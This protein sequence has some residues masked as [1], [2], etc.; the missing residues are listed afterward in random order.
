MNQLRELRKMT[1]GTTLRLV[2]AAVWILAAVNVGPATGGAQVSGDSATPCKIE[3][4]VFDGWQAEQISNRW[5]KLTI[6]PQLGGRLMQV[7]F[8]G[9]PYL[10]VNSK[11]KGQYFPPSE[12]AEKGRWFN[13][14][15]DKIWPLPEG[16][17]DQHH[18]PGPISDPLDDGTYLF[19]KLSES[20]RCAVRLDGPPD[21]RT[22]LQYSREISIGNDS[23]E[24]KFHAIMKN[25]S[26]H[27]IQWS[28]QSVTQYDT[29][30]PQTPASYNHEF[31]AFTPAN[32]HSKFP[33]GYRVRSGLVD[34][35]SYAVKENLF[36]L[37][38][39]PIQNEV[40]LDSAGGWLVV[41]D[42][43]THYAIVERF[44]YHHGA[45]YPG[46]A[47]VIFY[48]NGAALELN[49]QGNPILTASHPEDALFYMEAEL[50]SPIAKLEPGE[51]YWMDT[52][53]F[54]VR[55]GKELSAVTNAGVIGVALQAAQK[56][57]GIYLTGLFGVFLHGKI[58]AR[59]YDDRGMKIA[60]VP[61]ESV[62]PDDAVELHKEIK[63]PRGTA[64]VSIHL[65]DQQGNDRGPLG[66]AG[67][68]PIDE[69]S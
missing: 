13:Y 64:R 28:M 58:E 43:L 12:G 37:H 63:A 49:D 29:T 39:L 54:P 61:L 45:E 36:R 3:S 14:G 1:S 6:V 16:S 21:V 41:A 50:N 20:P 10:F 25:S 31:W 5:V 56:A 52:N 27:R 2:Q 24:I 47:S 34:D 11:Y 69:E 19:R 59:L 33:G 32:P 7:S 18:W 55:M 66:D 38:W 30:D 57:T 67:V 15:G 68:T 60:V 51:S 62:N 44:L 42:G 22:G 23:P 48:K 17:Q 46:E 9:H 53:W 65:L 35:P 26:G 40:W 4:T 8:G